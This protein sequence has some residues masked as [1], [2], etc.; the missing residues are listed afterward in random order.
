MVARARQEGELY[1]EY[2]EALKIE[3]YDLKL[4]LRLGPARWQAFKAWLATQHINLDEENDA[5]PDTDTS[6]KRDTKGE[7]QYPRK[8]QTPVRGNKQAKRHDI[9]G[10][11]KL[12]NAMSKRGT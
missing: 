11:R 5:K 10:K 2:R 6:S 4:R 1:E 7:G 9:V 3:D 12:S 8:L